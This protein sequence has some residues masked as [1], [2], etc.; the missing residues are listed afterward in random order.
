MSAATRYLRF[1]RFVGLAMVLTLALVAVGYF[2]TRSLSGPTGVVAMLWG[3]GVSALASAL[4]GVPL[5]FHGAGGLDGTQLSLL[6]MLLRFLGV[7]LLLAS[8]LVFVE[9]A[10]E[11]FLVWVVIGYLV[12][13]LGDTIFAVR[14]LR[15]RPGGQS[16]G[17]SSGHLK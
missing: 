2:P 17:K 6:A 3:C 13:L 8:V 4:S 16:G 12:L 9:V 7:L 1:V 14:L 11:P 10:I 15:D 5:A